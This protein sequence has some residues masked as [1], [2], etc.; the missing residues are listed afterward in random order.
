MAAPIIRSVGSISGTVTGEGRKDLDGGETVTCS[1]TESANTGSPHTWSLH[2]RPPGSAATLTTP[3]A[4]TCSFVVDEPGTYWVKCTVGSVTT[5]V[6]LG[7]PLANSNVRIPAFG[8]ELQY[9]GAGNTQGWHPELDLM[10]RWID[11]NAGG[12][13][14]GGTITSVV[15][16]NGL[17][18]GGASGAVTLHVAANADGSI[19]VNG[20]DIQVGTLATDGQHGNRGGGGLHANVV[21]GGAAGFMTGTQATQLATAVSDITALGSAVTTLQGRTLS[22]TAP[23]GGGGTIGTTNLTLTISAATTG[24]AGSM[25]AADKTKVDGLAALTAKGDLLSFSTVPIRVGVGSNGQVPTADSTQAVGWRWATPSSGGHAIYLGPTAVTPTSDKLS[26]SATNFDVADTEISPGVQATQVSLKAGGVDVTNLINNNITYA[27]LAHAPARSLL[28]NATDATA[29]LTAIAGS[30]ANQVFKVN[31][32]NTGLECALLPLGSL[33]NIAALS[34]LG[35]ATNGSAAVTAITAGTDGHVFRRSGTAVGFG[36]IVHTVVGGGTNMRIPYF[37]SSGL[38]TTSSSFTWDAASSTMTFDPSG[39][40][41]LRWGSGICNI[42]APGSQG[43]QIYQSAGTGTPIAGFGSLGLSIGS[44][45]GQQATTAPL[46][47][48]NTHASTLDAVALTKSGAQRIVKRG[49][50]ALTLG[51]AVNEDLSLVTNDLERIR[52]EENGNIGLWTTTH[53]S[54]V[55]VLSAGAA[56]TEPTTASATEGHLWYYGGSWK[57]M[58]GSGVP[59]TLAS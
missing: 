12:G 36:T 38:L 29:V 44:S 13:G 24:A 53:G 37:D 49:T 30:A 19:V 21:A 40:G 20:D 2:R 8:E 59:I 41:S 10:L 16:G 5:D 9:N 43:V 54:G 26:F 22:T 34:V 32:T 23:L 18:G 52:I 51:T 47:V 17:T 27:K 46:V 28:G 4:A 39:P 15:A 7:C 56:T 6:L 58:G 11:A 55:G 1:D 3:T 14:G 57:I 33:A 31:D 35:N 42:Q 25:S 45:A 50:G 48:A